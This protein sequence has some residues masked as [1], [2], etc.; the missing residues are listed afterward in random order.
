MASV[1]LKSK[2][3][4]LIDKERSIF[5]LRSVEAMLRSETREAAMRRRM[6]DAAER[7]EQDI[8]AGRVHTWEEVEAELDALFAPKPA[9]KPQAKRKA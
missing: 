9:R 8:E 5:M 2:V 7:S 4:K 1:Q 6:I 3:K